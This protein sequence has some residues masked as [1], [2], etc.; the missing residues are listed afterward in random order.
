MDPEMLELVLDDERTYQDAAKPVFLEKLTAVF[1]KFRKAGDTHLIPHSGICTAAKCNFGCKGFS[2]VGNSSGKRLDLVFEEDERDY[3]DIYYCHDFQSDLPEGEYADKIYLGFGKDEEDIF[4]PTV[5]Y[6]LQVKECEAA[7]ADLMQ[8]SGTVIGR[9]IYEGWYHKYEELNNR[10]PNMFQNYSGF[11]PFP[12]L[13]FDMQEILKTLALD[14]T[15]KEG[16][17]AFDSLDPNSETALLHWLVK[18]EKVGIAVPLFLIEYGEDP[19]KGIPLS[20]VENIFLDPKD[21]SHF[22]SF[23]EL[24]NR[25]YDNIK[26]K[27]DLFSDRLPGVDPFEFYS[28]SYQLQQRGLL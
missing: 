4:V 8:H 18:Y 28:L 20:R 10:L 16:L 11:D 7:M 14:I 19:G 12:Y 13:M 3:T 26:D 27:Y 22:L 2:F 9:E 17:K 5:K 23:Q 24:Y 1:K 21:Y 25:Y 6:L 15:A